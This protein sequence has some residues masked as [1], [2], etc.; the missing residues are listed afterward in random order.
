LFGNLMGIPE[1]QAVEPHELQDICSKVEKQRLL[2]IERLT[3]RTNAWNEEITKLYNPFQSADAD[4]R[5]FVQEVHD[6]LDLVPVRPVQL[7]DIRREIERLPLWTNARKA[8]PLGMQGTYADLLKMTQRMD[9]LL[10]C[11]AEREDSGSKQQG[12]SVA[13]AGKPS[14]AAL[15]AG[16]C[17]TRRESQRALAGK[18][19]ISPNTLKKIMDGKRVRS[20]KIAA[21]A[22]VLGCRYEDLLPDFAT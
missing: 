6:V 14:P 4:V 22:E 8:G 7:R 3:E 11:L 16:W 2:Q 19:G 21:V 1:S 18:A 15:I 17:K 12:I 13:P 20:E 10:A 9:D 5:G